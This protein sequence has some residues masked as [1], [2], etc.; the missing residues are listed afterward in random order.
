[1]EQIKCS[2]ASFAMIVII[3]CILFY[4]HS[5]SSKWVERLQLSRRDFDG[6]K[7][8]SGL[9]NSAQVQQVMRKKMENRNRNETRRW[10]E[11]QP[12]N[13]SEE[14]LKKEEKK[15]KPIGM[16]Q[17]SCTE[18]KQYTVIPSKDL[19]LFCKQLVWRSSTRISLANTNT[20][21][22]RRVFKQTQ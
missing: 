19:R 18:S 15:W 5:R 11:S 17:L 13:W 4:Q 21:C 22:L 6:Q 8:N 16:W 10:M 3:L 12:R 9:I 14:R 7:S 20:L 1:M 2:T